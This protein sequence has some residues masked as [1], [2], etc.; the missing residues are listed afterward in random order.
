MLRQ[1]MTCHNSSICCNNNITN[2]WSVN[3]DNK[4]YEKEKKS[5]F[6]LKN[7]TLNR[8]IKNI[9]SFLNFILTIP[10]LALLVFAFYLWLVLYNDND[11][12][13]L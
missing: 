9:L 1:Y 7:L 6:T 10:A 11:N 3:N 2:Y 4:E 8:A 13:E 12:N 5:I